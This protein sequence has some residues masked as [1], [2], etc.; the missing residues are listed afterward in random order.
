MGSVTNLS[1][2]F[3]CAFQLYEAK[4]KA[5]SST[6][7]LEPYTLRPRAPQKLAEL[8]RYEAARDPAHFAD[9][10]Y[11]ANAHVLLHD[12]NCFRFEA[13]GARAHGGDGALTVQLLD[14]DR[15]EVTAGMCSSH[16]GFW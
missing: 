10:V 8:Y 16:I 6:L 14:P 15:T 9:A 13:R 11:N 4:T 12:D 7:I 1:R 3:D 5:N 2:I